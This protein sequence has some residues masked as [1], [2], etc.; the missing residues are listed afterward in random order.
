[1]QAAVAKLSVMMTT[2]MGILACMTAAWWGSVSRQSL[3]YDAR[4]P[5]KCLLQLSDRY[6]RTPVLSCSIV[7][8][9]FLDVTCISVFWFH[10]YI[11]GGYWFLVLG[12]IVGGL[13]GGEP[14]YIGSI[15]HS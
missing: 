6:G 9:L 14:I 7:G 13:L 8:V 15:V 12:P 3:Q 4:L 11:P 5:R 10:N 2:S 1:M